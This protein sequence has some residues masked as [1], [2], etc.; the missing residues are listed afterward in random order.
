MNEE[1]HNPSGEPI[2]ENLLLVVIKHFIFYLT[3]S[4]FLISGLQYV[5]HYVGLIDSVDT[6]PMLQTAI[7]IST[8]L[9]LWMLSEIDIVT[10]Y[11]Y[12]DDE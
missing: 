2:I 11:E 7:T 6:L 8:L 4:I 3:S 9:I 12:E 1:D 10:G 5:M